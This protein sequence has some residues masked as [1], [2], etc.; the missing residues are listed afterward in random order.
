MLTEA[1]VDANA[2]NR[3]KRWV[4][5]HMLTVVLGA[6]AGDGGAGAAMM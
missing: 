2:R 5:L 1:A 6:G 3:R 4:E